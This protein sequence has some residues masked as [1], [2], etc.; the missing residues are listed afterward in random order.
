[1]AENLGGKRMTIIDANIKEILDIV[2]G[3]EVSNAAR[4]IKIESIKTLSEKNYICLEGN[5]KPGIKSDVEHLQ[6]NMVSKEEIVKIQGSVKI[7]NWIG[8]IVG[9]AIII[10]I[11]T[12]LLQIP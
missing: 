8:G 12:R 6:D 7:V 4:D 5:G 10:D 3:I 9:G 1:M 2:K 11:A